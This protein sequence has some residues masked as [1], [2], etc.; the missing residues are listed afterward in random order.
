MVLPASHRASPTPR[1]SGYS[2]KISTYLYGTFTLYCWLSQ[3]ILV[4]F[5]FI[6]QV[7][8]PRYGRNHTGLGS[9][10][11]ARHYLRN[12]YCFLFLCLLRCFSSAG[13]PSIRSISTSLRWVAPFGHLRIKTYQQFPVTF[14]SWSRPSSPLRA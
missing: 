8:Q 14:R 9:S 13:S 12:H 4:R 3:T 1:Y 6:I 5:Y 11:F 7:L 10:A 2:S